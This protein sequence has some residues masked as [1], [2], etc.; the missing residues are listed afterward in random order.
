MTKAIKTKKPND[1]ILRCS[2]TLLVGVTL[3]VSAMAADSD[4]RPERPKGPPAEAFTA[5]ESLSA[6]NACTVT[7]PRGEMTGS[8]KAAPNGQ[9][10]P[11]ACVPEGGRPGGQRPS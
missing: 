4:T 7:T 2:L 9:E 8:C 5:C 6:G 1:F 11:L 3:A 10:G